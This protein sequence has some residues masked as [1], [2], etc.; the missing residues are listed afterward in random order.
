MSET[1]IVAKLVVTWLTVLLVFL[2]V[3]NCMH[4]VWMYKN[5][6]KKDITHEEKTHYMLMTH[7]NK[8]K[9]RH[10]I[11]YLIVDIFFT[12]SFIIITLLFVAFSV[13]LC[14]F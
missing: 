4:I 6:Y 1:G 11:Y 9:R 8:S 2:N 12:A 10:A 13:A 5:V 3:D 14:F 7:H